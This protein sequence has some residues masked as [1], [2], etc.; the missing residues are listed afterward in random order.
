[1][2]IADEEFAAAVVRWLDHQAVSETR[3]TSFA[4]R[5]G[6][7]DIEVPAS[8][9]QSG[10]GRWILEIVAE[11]GVATFLGALDGPATPM[12]D[13]V[14]A[15]AFGLTPRDRAAVAA[16]IGALASCGLVSR[17]LETDRV[18]LTELGHAA[19]AAAGL[20]PA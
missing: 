8:T 17:E 3:L 16:R 18:A 11:P 13:L 19:L 14:N 20:V 4:F 15:G 7:A 6:Q 2:T 12:R 9:S 5:E 1:M 10:I